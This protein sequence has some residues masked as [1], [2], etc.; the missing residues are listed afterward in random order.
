MRQA[1]CPARLPHLHNT[2][3]DEV[4]V[5]LIDAPVDLGSKLVGLRHGEEMLLHQAQ[6]NSRT[7]K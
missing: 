3:L 2:A 4:T 5:W 6:S 1:G 7:L